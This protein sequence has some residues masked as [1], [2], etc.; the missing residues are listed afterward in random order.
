MNRKAEHL[1]ARIARLEQDIR[2]AHDQLAAARYE[3]QQLDR[4]PEVTYTDT[5]KKRVTVDGEVVSERG[6]KATQARVKVVAYMAIDV[7]RNEDG[8]IKRDEN[9]HMVTFETGEIGYDVT[10]S[11]MDAM[12][13][14]DKKPELADDVRVLW[15]KVVELS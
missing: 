4:Q 11:N 6:G 12:K 13:L 15:A 14:A 7:L 5:D 3:L 1:E 9:G 2:T 8:T 10:F